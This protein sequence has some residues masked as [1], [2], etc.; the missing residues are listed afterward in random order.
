VKHSEHHNLFRFDAVEDCIRKP[1][2]HGAPYFA[3][4]T[5]KH[6][7]KFFDRVEQSVDSRKEFL[8]ETDT[9]LFV[10]SVGTSQVLSDPAAED[11]G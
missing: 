5:S 2:D 9:L 11:Q 6:L 3:M 10:P 8:T 4:H 7:W 1:R